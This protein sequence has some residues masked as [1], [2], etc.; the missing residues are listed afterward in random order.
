MLIWLLWPV[1]LKK[2]CGNIFAADIDQHEAIQDTTTRDAHHTKFLVVIVGILVPN[3]N[4]CMGAPGTP[5]AETTTSKQLL[6]FEFVVYPSGVPGAPIHTVLL[7]PRIGLIWFLWFR[8]SHIRD[9]RKSIKISL[10]LLSHKRLVICKNFI[11][12]NSLQKNSFR[13]KNL[14]K[15]VLT[16]VI[17]Q[18]EKF[19]WNHARSYM[20]SM[21]F[22]YSYK[23]YETFFLKYQKLKTSV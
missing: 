4:V 14:E 9:A 21:I 11:W 1:C 2:K 17:E 16:K 5:E 13:N 8:R 19:H 23:D 20:I 7:I 12:S 3:S 18:K 10:V 6:L 15:M 22:G